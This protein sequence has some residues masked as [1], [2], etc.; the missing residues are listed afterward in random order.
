M[1]LRN[2][3]RHRGRSLATLSLLACGTFLVIAVGANRRD[4][5]EGAQEPSSGTGGAAL[6]GES[7]LPVVKD[8]NDTEVREA[9]ALEGKILKDVSFVPMRLREGDDASC[10]NLNR[11]QNP[12]LWGVRPRA[13]AGRFTFTKVMDPE[14]EED[15]WLSLERPGAEDVVPAVGDENTVLWVWGRRS[16]ARSTTRT[17]TAN[18]SRSESSA[19]WRHPYCRAP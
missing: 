18:R 17:N 16:A 15:P 13:L 14:A 19:W 1:G 5:N 8:L 9:F 3:I 6:F 12:Q 4:A 2:S 7:A 10:L 11:A